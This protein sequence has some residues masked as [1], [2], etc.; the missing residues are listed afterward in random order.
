MNSNELLPVNNFQFGSNE[1]AKIVS[2]KVF[3][4][5]VFKQNMPDGCYPGCNLSCTKGCES[6]VLK[7]G[8][9]AG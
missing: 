8:P 9:F 6:H 4:K 7:T 2:G 5:E 1:L 3:E